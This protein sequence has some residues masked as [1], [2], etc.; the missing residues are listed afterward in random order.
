MFGRIYRADILFTLQKDL[1]Q[2]LEW[3]DTI[4]VK[5]IKNFQIWYLFILELP[6]YS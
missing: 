6:Y 3:V 5:N 1:L 2:E 4:A